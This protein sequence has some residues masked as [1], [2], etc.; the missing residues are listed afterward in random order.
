MKFLIN[1]TNKLLR[2]L[3]LEIV[4]QKNLQLYYQHDYGVAGVDKYRD[5][6]VYHNNRKLDRI[7]ADEKALGLISEN[8][9]AHIKKVKAGICHGTRRGFEQAVLS[10][11]LKCA[12]IGAET[13]ETAIRFLQTVQWDFHKRNSKWIGA[14]SVVYSNSLDQAFDP[15]RALETWV[16]QLTEDVLLFIEHTMS[17]STSGASEMN[18]FSAYPMITPYLLF[19]WARGNNRLVNNLRPSHKNNRKIK[20]SFYFAEEN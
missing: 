1:T 11:L 10:R 16:E 15:K 14:Y 5:I 20:Q 6:Q 18:L 12:V 8:V 4:R 17:H 7:W 2:R 3:G 19:E 13:S 9:R